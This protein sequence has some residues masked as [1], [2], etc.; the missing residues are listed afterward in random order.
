METHTLRE[1]ADEFVII[2]TGDAGKFTVTMTTVQI[3]AVITTGW[4]AEKIINK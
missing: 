3:D 4:C 2:C 1:L